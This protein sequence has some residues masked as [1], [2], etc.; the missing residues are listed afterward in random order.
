MRERKS[1]RLLIVSPANEV[2]LF[3]FVHKGDALDGQDYWATPGGGLEAG[4]SFEQ[5]A[6]RE[7]WEETGIRVDS[8]DTPVGERR[9]VMRLP[10]GEDVVSVE[11]YFLLRVTSQQLSREG[12]TDSEVR[13]MAAHH[14]WS[15]EGYDARTVTVYPERLVGMLEVGGVW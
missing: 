2:L 11:R 3:R 8:V 6:V 12:W 14:W 4:E 5:A 13:V 1:A 9:F 7:L 15:R 10:S